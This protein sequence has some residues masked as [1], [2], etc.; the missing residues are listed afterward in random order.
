MELMAAME[1]FYVVATLD[2]VQCTGPVVFPKTGNWI[3]ATFIQ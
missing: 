1:T 3:I 2:V